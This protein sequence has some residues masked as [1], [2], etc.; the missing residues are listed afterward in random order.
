MNGHQLLIKDLEEFL[1]E[2][3]S[4]EFHDFRNEKYAT[5]KMALK[6]KLDA[7]AEAVIAGKYD[8]EPL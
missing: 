3:E 2:A 8:N 1:K 5:P 4:F 6:E 7:M